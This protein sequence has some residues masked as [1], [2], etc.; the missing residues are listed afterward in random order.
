MVEASRRADCAAARPPGS[1]PA[2]GERVGRWVSQRWGGSAGLASPVSGWAGGDGG[3]QSPTSADPAALAFLRLTELS[4]ASS[5]GR[6]AGC[7][8]VDGTNHPSPPRRALSRRTPRFSGA[9]ACARDA[10]AVY[11]TRKTSPPRMITSDALSSLPPRPPLLVSFP[12]SPLTH[13]FFNSSTLPIRPSPVVMAGV[14]FLLLPSVVHS[15]AAVHVRHPR[16]LA[17]SHRPGP[18]R[19]LPCRFPLQG[20]PRRPCAD[21]QMH[22]LDGL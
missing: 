9:A 5:H 6:A 12:L 7:S 4:Q 17:V 19:P 3:Q 1:T 16:H 11:I 21:A 13:H 20:D 2:P 10:R 15:P 22:Q 8:S 14:A 18:P